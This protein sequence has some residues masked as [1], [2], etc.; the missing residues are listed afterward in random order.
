MPQVGTGTDWEL[1][2]LLAPGTVPRSGPIPGNKEPWEVLRGEQR[3]HTLSR[4][5]A[6]TTHLHVPQRAVVA[7]WKGRSLPGSEE[8]GMEEGR[9]E[10]G[11]LFCCPIT[12][13]EEA[14]VPVAEP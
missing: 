4:I 5:P 6:V 8:G 2:V 10:E 13:C 9:L 14:H 12:S 1:L 11:G 7:H 3:P